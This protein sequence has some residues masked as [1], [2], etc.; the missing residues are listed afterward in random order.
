[1]QP[2]D[3]AEREAAAVAAAAD[4][5]SGPGAAERYGF[6][7]LPDGVAWPPAD[8]V[9]LP[10]TAPGQVRDSY[11]AIVVGA[12]AGGAWPRMCSRRRA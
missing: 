9:V 1:M 4:A 7:E 12:G 2:S 5:L 11:D 10:V 3:N 6:R 8:P